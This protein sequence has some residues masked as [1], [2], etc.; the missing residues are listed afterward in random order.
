MTEDAN[1][2]RPTDSEPPARSQRN[3]EP[4]PSIVSLL[5]AIPVAAARS[6]VQKLPKTVVSALLTMCGLVLIVSPLAL[7]ISWTPA[8]FNAV[9]GTALLALLVAWLLIMLGRED[10]R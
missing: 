3:D 5:F 2:P 8:I 9:L 1:R 7:W 4:P 10:Q 6:V